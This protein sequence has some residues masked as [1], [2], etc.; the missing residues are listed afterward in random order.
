MTL[1]EASLEGNTR[2]LVADDHAV[3]RFGMRAM[4]A[5]ARGFEVVAEAS[6][7][8]EVVGKAAEVRPDIVLMDIQMPGMN[9]IEAT[10]KIVQANPE[11]SV[12]VVTMFGDDD[13]VFSAMR[14]GARGYVLKGADA[15]EVTKVLRAVAEGEAYFGPEIA[16]RIMSFFSSPKPAPASEAFP[17]LTPREVEVLDLIARG[18]NNKEIA[19]RLYLS[20][21]TVRNHVSNVFLKLQVADRAQAIVRAREAGLGRDNS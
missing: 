13:S 9:G 21:K 15:E 1:P 20:Q 16:K 12:V 10:R 11:V 2:V 18:L 14:A 5:N 8:E 3:F 19:S 6:T 4:L 7:G 17:E